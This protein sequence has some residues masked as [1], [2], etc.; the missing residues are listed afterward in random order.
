SMRD[1]GVQRFVLR[2]EHEAGH[3]DVEV[4]LLSA[5][6]DPAMLFEVTRTRLEKVRL[7]RPVVGVRLVARELPP[8]APASRDLFDARNQQ[9]LPWPQLRERLR[10]R[11]GDEAVYA[12]APSGDPRPERAWRRVAEGAV[13]IDEAPP[14]PG[15][16]ARR[17][18]GRAG[19]RGGRGARR[20][21]PRARA[22]AAGR[23]RPPR[24]GGGARGGGGGGFRAAPPPPPPGGGGGGGGGEG[25]CSRHPTRA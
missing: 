25:R 9:Q 15:C 16:G 11:L 18:G 6:R 12:V 2:L 3:T 22:G 24:G 14:R 20:R 1:G 19:G 7:A 21:R 13:D 23:G 8:F 17:G 5:E 4:G 10:A